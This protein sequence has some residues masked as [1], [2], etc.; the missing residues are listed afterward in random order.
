MTFNVIWYQG[1]VEKIEQLLD[2]QLM[3]A[4]IA[5]DVPF[6]KILPE[7]EKERYAANFKYCIRY[8]EWEEG[9]DYSVDYGSYSK[10]IRIMEVDK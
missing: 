4:D 3:E 9:K 2:Q 1:S 8:I 6:A 10:F 5:F 7:N